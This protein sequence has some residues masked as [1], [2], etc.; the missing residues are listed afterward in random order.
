MELQKRLAANILNCG[1]G[2]VR[3]DPSK[4]GEIKEAITKFDVQRLINKG[5]IYKI[6]A[7]GISRARA[8]KQAVQKRKG[9]RSGHGSRKGSATA[10][11]NQKTMWIA[12]VRAQ[13]ALAKKLKEKKII[14]NEAFRVIYAKIKGGFFRSTKHL[15]IYVEEQ[16]MTR[17]K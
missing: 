8:K 15:K 1:P 12:N 4:L 5:T 13:R 3:F 6:Q 10:R 14:D 9:R 7:Q 2:R 11:L 17:K 16:E